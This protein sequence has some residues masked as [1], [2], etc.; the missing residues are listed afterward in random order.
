[1]NGS[2]HNGGNPNALILRRETRLCPADTLV[3][4]RDAA[5]MLSALAQQGAAS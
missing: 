5:Q 3:P 4:K 2:R 1:M